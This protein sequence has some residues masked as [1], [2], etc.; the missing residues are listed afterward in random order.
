MVTRTYSG[1]MKHADYASRLE[2]LSLRDN[3]V[4][5]PRDISNRFYKS[6]AWLDVRDAVIARDLGCDLGVPGH[7]INGPILVHHIDALTKEDIENWNVD[8]L[9]GMDN[10]ICTSIDTHNRIHYGEP[11]KAFSERQPGDTDLF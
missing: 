4:N 10:L 9:F 3:N 11:P 6:K 1:A 8:K 5:S 2:Y 7:Y